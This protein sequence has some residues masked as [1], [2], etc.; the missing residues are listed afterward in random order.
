M[1]IDVVSTEK[2]PEKIDLVTKSFTQTE[3]VRMK[4][5]LAPKKTVNT[6]KQN[7]LKHMIIPNII[8]LIILGLIFYYFIF[9]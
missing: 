1:S 8:A 6:K 7:K 4:V 9:I 5:P 2:I 3:T